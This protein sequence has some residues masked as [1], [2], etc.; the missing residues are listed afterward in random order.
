MIGIVMVLWRINVSCHKLFDFP[1]SF[2]KKANLHYE[3]IRCELFNPLSLKCTI[4][5]WF[6]IFK[7]LRALCGFVFNWLYYLWE[8]FYNIMHFGHINLALSYQLC[9][10]QILPIFMHWLFCLSTAY[11]DRSDHS[12]YCHLYSFLCSLKSFNIGFTLTS[13]ISFYFHFSIILFPHSMFTLYL[14]FYLTL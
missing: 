9:N 7:L 5:W 8:L 6:Q 2:F 3:K 1:V 14:F 11:N 12:F 13:D 4:D 10:S